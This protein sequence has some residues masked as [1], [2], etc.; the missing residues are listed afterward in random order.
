VGDF[1][2]VFLGIPVHE[3]DCQVC[4]HA[5]LGGLEQA[6]IDLVIAVLAEPRHQVF[7]F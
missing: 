6:E 2:A 3:S 7:A 1:Q 5:G 4:R